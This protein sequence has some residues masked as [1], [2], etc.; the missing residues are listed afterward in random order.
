MNWFYFFQASF[1]PVYHQWHLKFDRQTNQQHINMESMKQS[2]TEI[3]MEFTE[4]SEH[5][6]NEDLPY[7]WNKKT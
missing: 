4:N 5:Q 2:E 3:K 6:E 7:F 1:L